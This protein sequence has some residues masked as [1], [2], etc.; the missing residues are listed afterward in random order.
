M[1]R[2]IIILGLF[3][4]TASSCNDKSEE[5]PSWKSYPPLSNLYKTELNI[6]DTLITESK[7]DRFVKDS[8][9]VTIHSSA[10]FKIDDIIV[11]LKKVLLYKNSQTILTGILNKTERELLYNIGTSLSLTKSEIS[12]ITRDHLLS[13]LFKQNVVDTESILFEHNKYT[14]VSSSTA[15][16][17]VYLVLKVKSFNNNNIDSAVSAVYLQIAH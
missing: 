7:F 8:M 17:G 14:I 13:V 15:V 11:L 12:E 1:N 6:G 3:I 16:N 10:T 5:S 9:N 4:I 2:L